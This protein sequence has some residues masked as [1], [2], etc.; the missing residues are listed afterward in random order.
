MKNKTEPIDKLS[1]VLETI[2]LIL[3]ITCILINIFRVD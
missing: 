3:L 2:C 1:K